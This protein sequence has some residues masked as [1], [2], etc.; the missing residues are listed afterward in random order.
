VVV[1]ESN[2]ITTDTLTSEV[3]PGM[4]SSKSH[5]V[6]LHLFI[7]GKEIYH[8]D[9][10]YRSVG[11]HH[12]LVCDLRILFN[13]EE[14][15]GLNACFGRN[16]KTVQVQCESQLIINRWGLYVYE[17]KTNHTDD[18]ISFDIPHG[19][20]MAIPI[21]SSGLVPKV[22][23]HMLEQ[24]TG[25]VL[26]NM[27]PKEVFGDYLPLIELDETPNFTKTLLRSWM[28]AKANIKGESPASA[29]YGTSLRQEHEDCGWD[30][31]R[32]VELV[33]ENIPKLIDD[34]Y[35]DGIQSAQQIFEKVLREREKF[36]K[37]QDLVR[38]LDIDMPILVKI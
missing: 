27:N 25:H 19:D 23:P 38:G 4:V 32:V 14:W 36:L 37:K 35:T 17:Q 7:D 30:V 21:L 2:K 11:E 24:R 26:E 12:M 5:V 16:W 6:G 13:D 15:K 9:Y 33:Q 20:K 10:G 18:D 31:V 29:A 34:S 1:K 8:K 28:I 22:I 3:L